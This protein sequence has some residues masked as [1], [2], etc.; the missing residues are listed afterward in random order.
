[1]SIDAKPLETSPRAP[2][3]VS[4]ALGLLRDGPIG[5][6][7]AGTVAVQLA[8]LVSGAL[9]ARMLGPSN[10]GYLAILVTCASTIGQ[11]GAVGV[12]LATTFYLVSGRVSGDEVLDLVRRPVVIQ[13]V[14]LT[15]LNAVVIFGYIALTG[16]PIVVA[17]V[18][19]LLQ[20]SA[21]CALDLGIALA[22]GGRR[23]GVVSF[24]RAIAPA[25]YASSLII[26]FLAHAGTLDAVVVAFV[27]AS[28][29]GGGF[30]LVRGLRIAHGLRTDDSIVRQIGPRAARRELL[31]FGRRGYVGYLA[32]TDTFRLDQLIVGFLLS[33]RA[34]GI[35]AV[36]AA[37]TNFTRVLAANVGLSATSEVAHHRDPGERR[38]TLRRLLVVTAVLMTAVSICVGATAAIATPL[39]FGSAF[40]SA[41]PIAECL[42]VASWFF[43]MKRVT[44]DVLRGA[45]ELRLGT[46]AEALSLIVFLSLCAPA[47]YALGG[48]GVAAS[49]VVAAAAGGCYLFWRVKT[50]GM[51]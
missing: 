4:R 47:A 40:A 5:K 11:A 8:L 27:V 10:R 34:L 37:F 44:V 39:L 32:P 6:N 18:L 23:H 19:S 35:Y 25:L 13:V 1:M 48:I 26:L 17:A 33:P 41:V 28:V 43:S 30:M 9:S 50:L 16:A 36:G 31:A 21:A 24:G 14:T 7:L 29:A 2:T 51:I 3:T 15:T 42:L 22:L 49:L 45:G 20:M 38:A 46:R 12:A